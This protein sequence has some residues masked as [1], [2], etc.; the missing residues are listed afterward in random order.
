MYCVGVVSHF[1]YS[2]AFSALCVVN[3]SLLGH[4][5]PFLVAIVIHSDQNR[6]G[7]SGRNQYQIIRCYRTLKQFAFYS[8]APAQAAAV[9][10][11]S[12]EYAAFRTKIYCILRHERCTGDTLLLFRIQLVRLP[13]IGSAFCVYGIKR[14]GHVAI[15]E[16]IFIQR[17]T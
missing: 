12:R 3:L 2:A 13:N 15:I 10:V 14:A 17:R 4:K 11:H 9:R 8:F 6:V 5:R 7:V 16:Q 1:L